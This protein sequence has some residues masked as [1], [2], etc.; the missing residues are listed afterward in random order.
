MQKNISFLTEQGCVSSAPESGS[1]GRTLPLV[2]KPAGRHGCYSLVSILLSLIHPFPL[3]KHLSVCLWMN[4]CVLMIVVFGSVWWELRGFR[5]V[6][7]RCGC[8]QQANEAAGKRGVSLLRSEQAIYPPSPSLYC[9]QRSCDKW[10][11]R[12]PDE[13]WEWLWAVGLWA[14]LAALPQW[15]GWL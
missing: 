1:L 3:H 13:M 8:L 11:E 12:C 5:R 4:A 6:K 2:H 10:D 9:L 7:H 15:Q 14:W